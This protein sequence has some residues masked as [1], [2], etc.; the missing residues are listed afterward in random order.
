M[1]LKGGKIS[2]TSYLLA[3]YWQ[4]SMEENCKE[5]KTFLC[6]YGNFK[7]EAMLFGLVNAPSIFQSVIDKILCNMSF[8]RVYPDD[9]LILSANMEDRVKH[10]RKHLEPYG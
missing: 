2:T 9:S 6:R 5:M 3:D 4:I 8:A 10:F 1:E 7:F